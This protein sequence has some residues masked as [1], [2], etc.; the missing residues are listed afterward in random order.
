MNSSAEEN[1]S[2]LMTASGSQQIVEFQ[3]CISSIPVVIRA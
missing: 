1:R 2:L 3:D